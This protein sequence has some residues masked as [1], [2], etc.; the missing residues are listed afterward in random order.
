[1]CGLGT[2]VLLAQ[3]GETGGGGKATSLFE[4]KKFGSCLRLQ[5]ESGLIED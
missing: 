4:L 2:L 5:L 3:M 1:M